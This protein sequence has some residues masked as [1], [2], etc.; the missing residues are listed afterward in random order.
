VGVGG[1]QWAEDRVELGGEGRN[2]CVGTD[3]TPIA[4]DGVW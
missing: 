3:R 2:E 4:E 1:I